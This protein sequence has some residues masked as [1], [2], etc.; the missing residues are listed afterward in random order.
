M[1]HESE[2]KDNVDFSSGSSGASDFYPLQ[3]SALRKNGFVLIRDRPCKIVEMHVFST[4]KHGRAKIHFVG[5][6]IFTQRKYEDNCQSSHNRMV[7]NVIRKEYIVN[8]Y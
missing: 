4:G 5:I 2:S 6:D 1:A 7:P 3:C 8:Y